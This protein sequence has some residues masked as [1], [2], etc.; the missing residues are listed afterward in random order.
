MSK[1][2][3]LLQKLSEEPNTTSSVKEPVQQASMPGIPRLKVVF[4]GLILDKSMPI[5]RKVS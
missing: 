3:S 5:L 1:I 2:N 4:L